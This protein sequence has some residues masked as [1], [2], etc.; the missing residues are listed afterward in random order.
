[1]NI[2]ININGA[3]IEKKLNVLSSNNRAFKYA[4]ALFETIKG[5]NLNI[6]FL[7]DHYFRLMASMR[8]LRMEIPLHFTM[9]FFEAEILK[10]VKANSLNNNYRIRFSVY[11]KGDGK[12]TP[13]SNEIEYL[14][15][16][17]QL[18]III[19]ENYSLELF[20]DYYVY[21]G[22]LS[23]IKTTNKII[24]VLA[25]IYAKENNFDNCLLLNE[26]KNVVEVIN[27][28][29]FLVF[30]N[31]IKTPA[32]YEGCIK[33][34]IRK[35]I[36]EVLSKNDIYKIEETEISPFDLQKAD[37]VF[38]TNSIIGIQPVSNYK[39]MV[40]GSKV[41]NEISLILTDLI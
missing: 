32:I 26:K 15:E 20:K 21:S 39:K 3:L 28:N 16:V 22:L 12:Y 11:R 8:M 29:I 19:K 10:T 13:I 4:D 9:E 18:N 41:S 25:S 38:I 5:I 40:Y 17:E 35:K 2:M 24:N 6:I 23:T 37:E 14:I 34:I 31:I 27:G 7:E 33:G 30:G 36:I 1:M